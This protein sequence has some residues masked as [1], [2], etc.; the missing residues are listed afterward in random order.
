MQ[1][2]SLNIQSELKAIQARLQSL[3]TPSDGRGSSPATAP[4][5]SP[6]PPRPEPS[7][8]P[9]APASMV[10]MF[11][12][13][14]KN[15]AAHSLPTAPVATAF[16][17]ESGSRTPA[18]Q[19]AIAATGADARAATQLSK[20][21]Q[22]LE[23]KAEQVNHLSAQQEAA[24]LEIKAIAQQLERDWHST[25]SADHPLSR[26]WDATLT[27]L[28]ADLNHNL[29]AQVPYVERDASGAWVVTS[30]GIDLFRAERESE[31]MAQVLRR[32]QRPSRP[33][34]GDR[35][36]Q[37]VLALGRW[38][39]PLVSPAGFNTGDSRLT[40]RRM[41][42]ARPSRAAVADRPPMSMVTAAW[43]IGG[44]AIARLAIDAVLLSF[45]SFWI[46]AVALIV[47]PAAIAAYRTTVN[48]ESSI[49]WGYRLF[50][51]MVGL[52]LGGRLL[53]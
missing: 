49:L 4:R 39:Q 22:Q 47:A 35:V 1:D 14:A 20:L 5:N 17:P 34:P 18:P 31:Q 6:S 48:P 38:I 53:P 30:R 19:A 21:M 52:L 10:E 50:M 42:A 41:S 37:A 3:S 23:A 16:A 26:Q 51:I 40:R 8:R 36:V 33:A 25:Q 12:A 44:A 15:L 32:R 45:P 11:P 29:N 9:I 46:P 27:N 7:R 28:Q 13:Q 24:L 43:W 2:T